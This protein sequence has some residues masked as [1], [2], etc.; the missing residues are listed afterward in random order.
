LESV[1]S[2]EQM[3]LQVTGGPAKQSGSSGQTRVSVKNLWKVFGP[4]ESADC[5]TRFAGLS[6]P[7]VQANY[8]AVL[9]LQDVN[10][11]VM[12][13]ETFVVMGL[14]GSGKS[15]LVR[16][17]NRLIEPTCGSVFVDDED[18]LG[19]SD[20]D[21]IEFRRKKT[22]MVFQQFGLLPHRTVLEN[23][24]WGLEIQDVP[25]QEREERA[26]EVLEMVGLSGWEG[27]RPSAL[28]GGMQQRVGLARALASEPEIL[29]MDEP[30]SALDPLIRRDM[31][32]EL[33]R[34]Q[35]QMQ[36]TTIF[37]THDLAEA[38]KLGTRIAIMRDG[39]IIQ[40]GT[41]EE[42]VS[43]PID[44]YVAEFTRDVRPSTVLTVGYVM[45]KQEEQLTTPTISRPDA[46]VASEQTVDEALSQRWDTTGELPVMDESGK[47][48][49]VIDR[50]TLLKAA[51][52]Q[53][54]LSTESGVTLHPALSATDAK[55]TPS[56][57]SAPKSAQHN[58]MQA[59]PSPLQKLAS[60][61]NWI[62]LVSL[63]LIGSI[64][65]FGGIA[66][67]P[68][69]LQIGHEFSRWV[70][71][72]VDWLVINGD[73]LF[74][75]I[76]VGLLK[77]VLLPLEDWLLSLPW[78]LVVVVI[79][80]PSYRIVGQAFAV[81]AIAMLLMVVSLGIF[82]LAMSTLALVIVATG[83][84]VV[85]GVPTGILAARNVRFDIVLRPV[86]D[87]MQTMPSFVYLIPAL[88]LFG[89]GKVPAIMATVIYAVP[90]IIR[91]TNLGIRQVDGSVIEA[92]RAFGSTG[93]Q[94]LF[95]VQIPLAMPT[96]MAGLNQTIMMG[97]A[98]V[99]IA[100]M[101]GAKGL[102]VEVINGIARLD[103]GRGLIGGLGI[104]VMAVILDRITQG[105]GKAR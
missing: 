33:V 81:L 5:A 66:N 97:L 99:V 36:K 32:N 26:K 56:S 18:V 40:L 31:Q 104:V 90:P 3:A 20:A 39:A 16:C 13:G 86:L 25:V 37:I 14:S 29:L 59:L 27:Y 102:G 105:L 87:V 84:S 9:A 10:I 54:A 7:E 43:N 6:K 72:V 21:L 73:P 68:D 1:A 57:A 51:F 74:S 8:N 75:A 35:E 47:V 62:W 63:L 28:S 89:L 100:A 55:A 82:E 77:Y 49:G 101:I 94:L 85:I 92:A 83:L 4:D 76:N 11:D 48:I 42:I 69:S 2:R 70:N 67:V 98:M 44:D 22:S 45:D 65:P 53:P 52:Q 38:V 58:Y 46:E 30:F 64:V 41:P 79:A 34:L 19:Y 50:D 24:A 60:L 71:S 93:N 91:L 17:L 88:M 12:D 103:V 15:T 61:P 80:I 23:A 95:K 78:W 96:V